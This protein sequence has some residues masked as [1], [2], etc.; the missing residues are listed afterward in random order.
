MISK[1]KVDF[2]CIYRSHSPST[3]AFHFIHVAMF[4]TRTTSKEASKPTH[5]SLI[6]FLLCILP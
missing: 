5:D 4:L 1:K 2:P 3:G 6:L